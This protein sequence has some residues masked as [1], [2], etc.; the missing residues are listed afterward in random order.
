MG[1]IERMVSVAVTVLVNPNEVPARRAVAEADSLRF[2][3]YQI[4]LYAGVLPGSTVYL[5]WKVKLSPALQTV[6]PTSQ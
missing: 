5:P 4:S 3:R 1:V 6:E 2:T